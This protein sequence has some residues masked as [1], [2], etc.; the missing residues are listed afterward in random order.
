MG[1]ERWKILFTWLRCSGALVFAGVIGGPA[2][3]ME[4]KA[5]NAAS[6]SVVFM[7]DGRVGLCG[8]DLN[9]IQ[10]TTPRW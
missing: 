10:E 5:S 9:F 7:A 4:A 1:S 2:C 8:L 6:M 3:A